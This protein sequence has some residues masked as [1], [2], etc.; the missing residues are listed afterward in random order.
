MSHRF[1]GVEPIN[2]Q[3]VYGSILKLTQSLIKGH[4]VKSGEL[5]VLAFVMPIYHL[6]YLLSIEA[7]LIIS[8]PRIHGIASGEQPLVAD[9]LA[10]A[11]VGDAGMRPELYEDLGPDFSHQPVSKRHVASPSRFLLPFR[12]P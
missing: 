8:P 3:Q 9:C 6:I 5:F 4:S 11:K 12:R 10:E 7:G 2:V 1:V